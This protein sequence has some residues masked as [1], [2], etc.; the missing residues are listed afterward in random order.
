MQK[1]D[2]A[3]TQR[4]EGAKVLKNFTENLGVTFGERKLSGVAGCF[5]LASLR[6]CA[7]ALNSDLKAKA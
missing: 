2:N 5:I 7:L 4:C 1:I 6:L 3:K